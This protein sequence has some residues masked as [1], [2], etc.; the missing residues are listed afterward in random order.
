MKE[1]EKDDIKEE[2]RGQVEKEDV[3]Q[4]EEKLEKKDD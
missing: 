4:K 2:N 3:K 1:Q